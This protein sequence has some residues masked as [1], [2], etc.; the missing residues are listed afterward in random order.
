MTTMNRITTTLGS[1]L[2][3]FAVGCMVSET[4]AERL[5][6]AQGYTEIV[7]GGPAPRHCGRGDT[8]SRSFMAEGPTGQPV[9]GIVCCGGA[10]WGKSCT[11]RLD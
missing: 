8:R 11:L 4:T 1:F 6:E 9:R 10:V 3:S 7:L 2:L 5:L